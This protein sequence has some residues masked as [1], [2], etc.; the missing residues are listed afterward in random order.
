MTISLALLGST[1]SIGTQVL[2]VIRTIPGRFEVLALSAGRNLQLLVKQIEEFR[3]Q[4]VSIQLESDRKE[5]QAL[6][7]QE[8]IDFQGEI[9]CGEEGLL[10]LAGLSEASLVIVGLVGLIGLMPSLMALRIGKRVFTA[11]KETFVAAGHLVKP[12]LSQII[13]LDSEHSGVFQ[14][15]QAAKEIKEVS[16]LYLTASGGPFRTTP[17]EALSTVTPSQALQHPK[18]TMGAKISIDSATLMNKGLEVIEAHW[19]FGVP[20]ERIS[21]LVHPESIIHGGLQFVD[22]S[23]LLQLGVTDMRGPIQY[24]LSYPERDAA[25]DS[26]LML[27]LE[28][29]SQLNLEAPDLKR[30]PCLK[31]AY[32]A[33]RLA[34]GATTVLNGAN[35][36]LVQQFLDEKISFL[37]IPQL[38]ER[39][40]DRYQSDHA[41]STPD[42]D[43]VFDL[44]RWARQF[45]H[46]SLN[47][48]FSYAEV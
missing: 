16:K 44:D 23:T 36:V 46:E 6:L 7:R 28:E 27:G 45:I 40:L 43:Q 19:L 26:S 13:P 18:W 30:F 22:G 10:S 12:Y 35:E 21:V 11:N 2:D 20:L 29:L 38:L 17:I 9:L 33:G 32:E 4:V 3:P 14:C 39:V 25:C 5:L 31:L 41:I 8:G 24:A 15:L 37:Q 1:G 34:G 48:Q 42:L 47:K